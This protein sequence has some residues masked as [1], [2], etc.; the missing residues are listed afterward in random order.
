VIDRLVFV[1]TSRAMFWLIETKGYESWPAVIHP[2]PGKVE[3]SACGRTGIS[4]VRNGE[5]AH[6][7][8]GILID[9]PNIRPTFH[10]FVGS[11][12]PWHTICDG[13]PQFA[14]LPD[15]ASG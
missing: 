5:F 12:A 4:I 9:D 7:R 3:S 2:I 8:L 6:V 11:K 10:I 13:L 1:L 14:G 15:H